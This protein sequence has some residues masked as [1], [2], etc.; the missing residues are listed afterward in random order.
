MAERSPSPPVLAA[1]VAAPP[2]SIAV[3][4]ATFNAG[5]V[6]ANAPDQFGAGAVLHR[7]LPASLVYPPDGVL[8]PPNTNVI[9]VHFTL[10]ESVRHAVRSLIQQRD[11]RPAHLHDPAPA[12]AMRRGRRL[13]GW[14]QFVRAQPG[15]MGVIWRW[16]TAAGD[17][18]TVVRSMLMAPS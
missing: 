13:T 3:A 15:R 17:P 16:P 11:H 7:R 4:S 6:P 12:L 2:L 5:K 1:P 18:V 10:V 8:I 14:L 9:E